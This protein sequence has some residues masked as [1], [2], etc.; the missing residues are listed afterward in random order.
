[1]ETHL[2]SSYSDVTADAGYESE[3]NY[4][5]LEEK[6]TECYI[7]PQNYERSK[8]KK[9]KSNMA[10]RENMPYDA[11]LDEYACQAGKKLRAVYTASGKAKVD[12]RAISPITNVKA[13]KGAHTKRNVL[14]QK[15]TERFKSQRNL[16]SNVGNLWSASPVKKAFFCGQTVL[17]SQRVPLESLSRITVSVNFC[18]GATRKFLLRFSL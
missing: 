11:A 1:M 5:Y 13:V 15:E 8:T 18:F 14:G 10:L 6:S 9:Y 17:F 3:E 12:L 16:S 7:K 4:T 2:G